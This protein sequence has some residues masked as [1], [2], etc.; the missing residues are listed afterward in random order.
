MGRVINSDSP[1]QNRTRL[2]KLISNSLIIISE[3]KS[4]GN[5]IN[6]LI[7][8]IILSLT[9]M[10]KTINQ[11][12]APWERRDYWIKADQFRNEWKWVSEIRAQLLQSK[13]ARGW[14]KVP[15]GIN[16]LAEKV[17]MVEPSKRMQGK[18]FW[19]GA[20]SVMLSQK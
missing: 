2:L 13:T 9:E 14:E 1:L 5:D 8:F 4:S 15:P 12:T 3:G 10:E 17:K 7:A 20:Y 19:K 18:E 16:E 6:D 11:T